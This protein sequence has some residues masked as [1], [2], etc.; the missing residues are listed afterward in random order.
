MTTSYAIGNNW[1]TVADQAAG[2]QSAQLDTLVLVSK[3]ADYT[4]TLA[5]ANIG[6][7]HPADDPSGR[8]FTIPT[9]VAVAFPKGTK[10][11]IF[12]EQGAGAISLAINASD[13]LQLAGSAS[14][15]GTR[16]IATGGI[17][18]P[19]KITDAGVAPAIWMVGGP[20]VT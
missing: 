2:P 16:T 18:I 1:V 19:T 9:D 3:S 6:V 17:A 7:R 10:L 4:F 11:P 13:V 5:D 8:T 15:V 20:G 12:V 14:T